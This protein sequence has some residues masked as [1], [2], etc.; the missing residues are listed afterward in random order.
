MVRAQQRRRQPDD[1]VHHGERD[2]GHHQRQGRGVPGDRAGSNPGRGPLPRRRPRGSRGG[3]ERPDRGSDPGHRRHQ[4]DPVHRVRRDGL[5]DDRDGS[6]SR[7][8]P[9]GRR[10]QKQHRRHHDVSDR[11]READHP[12]TDEPA[13]GRRHRGLRRHR[14][15][16]PEANHGAG[17]RR[18]DRDSRD[19]AGRHR[20]RAA[21]R[22]LDR[23]LRG[24]P[25][26]ARHDLRSGGG[27]GAP[28]VP[29]P[30][31]RV[32]A[33]GAGGDPAANDRAGLPRGR[34]RESDPVDAGRRQPPAPRRRGD[35]RR[36]LRGDGSVRAVRRRADDDGLGLPDRGAERD[37]A[38]RARHRLRRGSP[39][40]APRGGNAHDLAGLGEDAGQPA[41]ADAPDRRC[42]VRARLPGAGTVPRAAPGVL[43]QPRHPH[44]VPRCH[45]PDAG[46]RGLRER[47]VAVRVRPCPRHR[48]RRR[49]HRRREHLPAPGGARRRHARLDRGRPPRSRS[50][51]HS[52]S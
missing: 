8:A 41:V 32:G 30:A 27:R 20:E 28:L 10:G 26:A 7:C 50:R 5:G 31:G 3:G 24:R 25:A 44:L 19:H 36:R 47:A 51:S 49:H 11:D 35:R 39:G 52:P 13:A 45:R 18:A 40:P 22:D 33:D 14:S 2:P 48:R 17:S 34:V 21:L 46:P 9:R 29:G 16:H 15:V 38:R 1:G 12:R 23:G 4:A 37:R 43:G 6:G 42:R